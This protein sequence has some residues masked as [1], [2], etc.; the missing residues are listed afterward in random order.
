MSIRLGWHLR[1]KLFVESMFPENGGSITLRDELGET[2]TLYTRDNEW[3]A[4][5]RALP[6]SPSFSAHSFQSD[7][8]FRSEDVEELVAR[9]TA[10]APA[11]ETPATEPAKDAA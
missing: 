7:R 5:Y 1:G 8:V 4:L 6:L 3:L 11:A 2:I 9:L 10:I